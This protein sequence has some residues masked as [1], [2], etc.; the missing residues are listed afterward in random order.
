MVPAG[1]DAQVEGD[2]LLGLREI[3]YAILDVYED[4]DDGLY[5]RVGVTVETPD[6]PVDA[7]VYRRGPAAPWGYGRAWGGWE[8]T[9]GESCSTG[10]YH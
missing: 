8:Q 6:G 5:V 2:L 7:W 4:V 10:G 3:E 1:P 9:R